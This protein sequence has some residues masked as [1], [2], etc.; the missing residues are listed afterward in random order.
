MHDPGL[1][2]TWI[3]PTW[4]SLLGK[5]SVDGQKEERP[6]SS[7]MLELVNT[8]LVSNFGCFAG[9]QLARY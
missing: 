5:C 1:K 8:G 4:I 9:Q 6:Q 3:N 7:L 2:F